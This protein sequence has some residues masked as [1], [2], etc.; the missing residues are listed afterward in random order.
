V[1]IAAFV[2][3]AALFSSHKGTSMLWGYPALT[4][5]FLGLAIIVAAWMVVQ[6]VR[7]DL[8]QQS[9]RRSR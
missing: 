3:A 6:M 4:I 7:S 9:K 8:R 2:L 1:I 5:V